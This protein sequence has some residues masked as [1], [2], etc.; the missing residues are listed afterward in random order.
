[1]Q[2]SFLYE[3]MTPIS[4]DNT[5]VLNYAATAHCGGHR[6]GE[7]SSDA[8]HAFEPHERAEK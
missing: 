8:P 1:M 2:G 3:R 4:K 5:I 6:M 7:L